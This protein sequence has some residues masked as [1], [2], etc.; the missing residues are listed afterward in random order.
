MDTSMDTSE[1]ANRDGKEEKA[2]FA[3][4]KNVR[5]GVGS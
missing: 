1:S 3:A 2:K 5:H 4:D